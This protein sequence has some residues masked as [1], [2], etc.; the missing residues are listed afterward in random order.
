MRRYVTTKFDEVELYRVV[1]TV[2]EVT[3]AVAV[4]RESTHGGS[5]WLFVTLLEGQMLDEAL[6]QRICL[7][8]HKVMGT[9]RPLR[10]FQLSS[11]PR[12]HNGRVMK[13]AL[14]RFINQQELPN[15]AMMQNPHILEEIARVGGSGY[16]Y[17]ATT[18]TWQFNLDT[19]G[20]SQ[21]CHNLVITSDQAATASGMQLNL[22]K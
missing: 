2:A 7:M 22:R 14:S 21:G 20:L 8:V 5:T 3:G 17:D 4:T 11:L 18:K 13:G 9:A 15:W 12:T 10:I 16:Q 1:L 19:K 6:E